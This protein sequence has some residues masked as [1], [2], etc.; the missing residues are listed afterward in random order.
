MNYLFG[1]IVSY[2]IVLFITPYLIKLAIKIDFLD[3]PTER[4][5][6]SKPMPL[7]GGTGI[8]IGFFSSYMIFFKQINKTFFAIFIASLL[9]YSIGIVDDWYKT[10][11]QEFAI[12]PR[13]F[14]HARN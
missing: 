9:I 8:F 3:K 6:H 13:L 7:I 4:K 14:V 10:R 1:F 11:G 2:I 5:N 12:L